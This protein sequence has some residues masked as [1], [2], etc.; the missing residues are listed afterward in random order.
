MIAMQI[1]GNIYYRMYKDV[2]PGKELLVWYGEE[3]AVEIGIALSNG[4][5][6]NK[7]D[8]AKQQNCKFV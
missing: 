5:G 1:H 4:K 6:R 2:E 8:G 3:M 7:D